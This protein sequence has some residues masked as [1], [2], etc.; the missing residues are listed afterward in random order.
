MRSF[1]KSN[2][3]F[4]PQR[5]RERRGVIFSFAAERPANKNPQP[6]C[7]VIYVPLEIIV[8]LKKSIQCYF[9]RRAVVFHFLAS[10]QKVKR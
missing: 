2:L 5:R 3:I 4:A 9:A 8:S 10:Q 7:G 1:N 6:L